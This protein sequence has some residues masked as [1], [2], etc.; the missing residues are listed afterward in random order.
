MNLN[1]VSV[2]SGMLGSDSVC[3]FG[4][5]KYG[6]LTLQE[7]WACFRGVEYLL[8]AVLLLYKRRW[9]ALTSNIKYYLQIN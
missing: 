4:E 3:G 7:T 1:D 9:F 5:L 6:V 2:R 8:G